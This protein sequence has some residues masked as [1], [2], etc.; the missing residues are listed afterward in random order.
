MLSK[1]H[2]RQRCTVACHFSNH[3]Q[4]GLK[5]TLTCQTFPCSTA[6]GEPAAECQEQRMCTIKLM[7][8]PS[9]TCTNVD[10]SSCCSSKLKLKHH[11]GSMHGH[12]SSTPV[13]H[14]HIMTL[15]FCWQHVSGIKMLQSALLLHFHPHLYGMRHSSWSHTDTAYGHS[16]VCHPIF[17]SHKI[18][19][20]DSV[21]QV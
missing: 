17:I 4:K 5:F 8:N 15:K 19:Q 6:Q 13:A 9:V 1:F 10:K 11:G 18:M 16:F 20:R 12:F 21:N 2:S 7:L 14:A 3:L